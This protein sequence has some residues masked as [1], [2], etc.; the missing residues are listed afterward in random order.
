MKRTLFLGIKPD[1]KPIFTSPFR[2]LK[3]ILSV[4]KGNGW[5]Y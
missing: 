1:A 5:I 2:D 3:I 4:N